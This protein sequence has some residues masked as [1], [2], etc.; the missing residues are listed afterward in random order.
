MQPDDTT[1]VD[2]GFSV[3]VIVARVVDSVGSGVI[4]EVAVTVV[5]GICSSSQRLQWQVQFSLAQ[6]AQAGCQ[7]KSHP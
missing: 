5:C 4:A 2:F 3:V 1:A 6:T 7:Q